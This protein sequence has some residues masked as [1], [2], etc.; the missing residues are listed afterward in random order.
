MNLPLSLSPVHDREPAAGY[1]LRRRDKIL[2][3]AF[4]LFLVSGFILARSLDPD[5]RGF[6]TH[7]RL[8]LPPCTLKLYFPTGCPSCGMT[9]SFAH[10]TRGQ[11]VSSVSA[12]PGGFLLA[13]ACAALIP[14][15]WFSIY[16][17]AMWRIYRPEIGLIWLMAIVMS[18]A[19]IH[20]VILTWLS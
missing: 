16:R 3:A 8:G 6:G 7:Q 18:T 1:V 11:W 2:L 4:S 14:W 17:G 15:S 12:N 9:T 20:W 13:L 5:P 10:F 19:L